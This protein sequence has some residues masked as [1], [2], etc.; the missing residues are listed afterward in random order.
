M[1]LMQSNQNFGS[2]RI[3]HPINHQR[4]WRRF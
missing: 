1:R 2:S 3:K 4:Y